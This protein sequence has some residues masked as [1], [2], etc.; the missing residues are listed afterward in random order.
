MIIDLDAERASDFAPTKALEPEP[1]DIAQPDPQKVF[2]QGRGGW[3]P[4]KRCLPGSRLRERTDGWSPSTEAVP[5][6]CRGAR[7]P[8]SGLK[9]VPTGLASGPFSFDKDGTMSRS[10]PKLL[11]LAES[12]GFGLPQPGGV[13]G[14]APGFGDLWKVPM[15]QGLAG[16]DPA[17]DHRCG[18]QALHKPDRHANGFS[19]AWV[20]GW[21]EALNRSENPLRQHR[22]GCWQRSQASAPTT[23]GL[24][25]AVLASIGPVFVPRGDQQRQTHGIKHFPSG[26]CLEKHIP[27]AIWSGRSPAGPKP[28]PWP[29]ITS[30]PN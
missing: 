28:N 23:K 26:P 9:G 21:P 19:P 20:L 25:A 11:A 3:R 7:W 12:Q 1:G 29:S 16:F 13:Q 15:A 30:A 5:R 8:N 18:Q 4:H 10:E 6:V 2:E 17:G 14:I 24:G 22:R 27:G